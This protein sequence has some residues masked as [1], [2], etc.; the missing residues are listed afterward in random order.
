MLS[1]AGGVVD[2]VIVYRLAADIFF[3]CVNASNSDK[4]YQWISRHAGQN[5]E[6]ENVSDKYA[7]L[8]LQ[9]PMAEKILQPLTAIALADIKSFYFA[10]GDVTSLRCLIARTGY[11]GEAGFELYCEAAA[12]EQLWRGLLEAGVAHGLAPA[13]LGA[14]DTLRLEKAYPLYGHELDDTTTPLEAGL[15]WVVKFSK[16]HFIGREILVKQKEAGPARKLVGVEPLSRPG[17]RGYRLFKGDRPIGTVTSGTRSPSLENPSRWVMSPVPKPRS[18]IL[19]RSR[20]AAERLVAKQW[21]CRFTVNQ[22][23]SGNIQGGW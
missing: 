6:V 9:G 10:F 3:I 20:F 7:Q 14:R 13:G 8:A 21:S 11:T 19:S 15:D 5:V 12:A 18:A 16:H 4:D 1:D 2:D 23:I 17:A 22:V